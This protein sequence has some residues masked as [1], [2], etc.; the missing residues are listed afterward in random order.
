MSSLLADPLFESAE[1]ETGVVDF[2]LDDEI[3]YDEDALVRAAELSTDAWEQLVMH[4]GMQS[5][6]SKATAKM[7]ANTRWLEL[8]RHRVIIVVMLEKARMD[9]FYL[10]YR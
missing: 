5:A 4:N 9:S 3:E 2:G 10:A 8:G 1:S 6:A 7:L